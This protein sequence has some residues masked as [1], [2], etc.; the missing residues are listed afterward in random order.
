MS[1]SR[2]Q[3]P[4]YAA[5][6][7]LVVSLTAG[8]SWVAIARAGAAAS[9]IGAPAPLGSVT[10]AGGAPTST[11]LPN[12]VPP[13]QPPATSTT[14]TTTRPSSSPRPTTSSPEPTRSGVQSV[15]T[16]AGQVWAYCVGATPHIRSVVATEGWRFEIAAEDNGRTEVKF[17]PPRDH[18]DDEVE[19]KVRCQ[20]G[21]PSFST[22]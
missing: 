17:E 7:L 11:D 15:S 12:P 19:V 3:L 14:H 20:S 10:V 22:E 4:R 8:L 18:H 6:W 21:S 13:T 5:I 1:G 9:L 2:T 16:P